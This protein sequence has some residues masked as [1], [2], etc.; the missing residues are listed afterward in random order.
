MT[1]HVGIN[2]ED[3]NLSYYNDVDKNVIDVNIE[4]VDFNE[5]EKVCLM[6]EEIKSK[7]NGIQLGCVCI[8]LWSGY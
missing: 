6:F 2:P 5:I 3:G 1:I 8:C 7:I 4:K